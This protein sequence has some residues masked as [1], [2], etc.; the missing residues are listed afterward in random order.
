[1]RLATPPSQ[2]LRHTCLTP[3]GQPTWSPSLRRILG[4]RAAV[5]EQAGSHPLP[6]QRHPQAAPSSIILHSLLLG[7]ARSPSRSPPPCP[8]PRR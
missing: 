1:M 4:D 6:P 8:D 2:G 5:A 7:G 3:R